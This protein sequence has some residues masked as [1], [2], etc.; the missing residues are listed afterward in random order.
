LRGCVGFLKRGF[1]SLQ[2]TT[3][4]IKRLSIF[5]LFSRIEECLFLKKVPIKILN[6]PTFFFETA[7]NFGVSCFSKLKS[8]PAYLLKSNSAADH[9]KSLF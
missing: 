9:E 2:D 1:N 8:C 7:S 6:Y 5:A 3:K 4:V